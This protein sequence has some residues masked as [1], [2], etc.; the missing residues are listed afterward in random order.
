[1][2]LKMASNITGKLKS[3]SKPEL[4]ALLLF[5]PGAQGK[6]AEPIVGST[7]LMKIIFL[8]Y[9]EA[10]LKELNEKSNTFTAF[11]FGPY[12]SE[13]FDAIE[14]LRILGLVQTNRENRNQGKGTDIELATDDQTFYRLSDQG[15]A[16]VQK[17][18][19]RVTPELYKTVSNYKATYSKK[20]LVEILQYVYT[21]YPNFAT[22]SEVAYKF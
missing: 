21:K 16:R 11:R 18:A 9:E 20:P 19:E 2:V 10:K 7:R 4:I 3:I 17:L 15:I 14:A 1:M 12:D 8:L 5:V 13:V 22:R 6:I